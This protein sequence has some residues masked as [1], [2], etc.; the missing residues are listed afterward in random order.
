M[1]DNKA[2]GF[3][4]RQAITGLIRNRSFSALWVAQFF[5]QIGDRFRNVAILFLI[6]ELTGGNPL[7]LT[8]YALTIVIPQFVVG[9]LGGAVVDRVDRKTVMIVSD[10]LRGA[11]M[12][13]VLLVRDPSQLW[14]IY[15]TSVGLEV[16]SVF[17]YPAR[18]AT[19]PNIVGPGQLMTAN[20]L[21]QAG[22]IVAL[23]IGSWLAGILTDLLG[24]GFAVFFDSATFFVSAGAL[25]F[26]SVPPLMAAVNGERASPAELWREIKDGLRYIWGQRDLKTVLIVSAVAMLG[27]GSMIVLGVSYLEEK[28]NLD[29][30]GYGNTLAMVGI[31]LLVGG[32]LLGR[33]AGRVAANTLVGGS[34]IVVGGA[35]I[36]FAGAGS[37]SVVLITAG[38]VGVCLVIARASLDTFTQTLVPDEMLGR[39]QSVVQMTIAVGIGAAQFL[40]G[41]SASLFGNEITFIIAGLVTIVAGVVAMVTLREAAREMANHE[42]VRSP[43]T[44]ES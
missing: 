13:P 28:L 21:M 20:A 15:I 12:L 39:V 43:S 41:I 24:T 11:F 31:G 19:L 27:L 40:A 1:S 34:L 38:V 6:N 16:V 18:N 2:A 10:V 37:Y 32:A 3:V 36:A 29:A 5:S 23:V 22:Y 7:A 14:I 25:T 35:M 8:A 9:L 17:F 30:S 44:S 26:M 42:L 4:G 33:I